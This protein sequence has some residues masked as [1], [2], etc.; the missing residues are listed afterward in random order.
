[1]VN[2]LLSPS[3]HAGD[4]IGF[5]PSKVPVPAGFFSKDILGKKQLIEELVNR[6]VWKNISLN[7]DW[8]NSSWCQF[9]KEVRFWWKKVWSSSAECSGDLANLRLKGSG[10]SFGK[11]SGRGSSRSSREGFCEG[12]RF[13][14]FQD[15]FVGRFWRKASGKVFFERFQGR[16]WLGGEGFRQARERKGSRQGWGRFWMQ[17]CRTAQQILAHRSCA[18]QQ[19]AGVV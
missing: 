16:F 9:P 2:I 18:L 19:S 17:K 7:E 4:C 10:V 3:E 11:G 13:G 5:L 14:K 6:N 8:V 12:S 15:R 1:M